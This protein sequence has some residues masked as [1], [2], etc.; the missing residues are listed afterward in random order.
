MITLTGQTSGRRSVTSVCLITALSFLLIGCSTYGGLN[1]ETFA[2]CVNEA[3][4]VG[5]YRASSTLRNDDLTFIVYT[6]PNVTAEQA[7]IANSCIERTIDSSLPP[8]QSVVLP[9]VAG[10]PQTITTQT[11]GTTVTETFTYGSPPSAA[12]PASGSARAPTCNLQMTG[13]TG[14]ICVAP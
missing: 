5:D 13:G 14:Y 9:D 3:G 8:Q 6:G 1:R 12:V 2:A 11:N 4:I 7:A 10:V